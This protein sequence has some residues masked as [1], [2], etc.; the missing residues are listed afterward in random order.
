MR[1][2][3]IDYARCCEW[4]KLFRIQPSRLDCETADEMRPRFRAGERILAR[5]GDDFLHA[6]I[7]KV[8]D[9]TVYTVGMSHGRGGEH[10]W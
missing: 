10:E 6:S 7:V 4:I 1:A 9:R 3:A 2:T 8:L 5:S